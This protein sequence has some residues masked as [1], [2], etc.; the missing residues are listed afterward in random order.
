[1]T[2]SIMDGAVLEK[3]RELCAALAAE[4]GIIAIRQRINAFIS[5]DR[6]RA[7]YE[8][9]M[10]AGQ[11]LQEKQERAQPLSM[12]EI[13]E[14]ERQRDA[15]FANPVARGFL[16]AQD[17]LHRLQDSIHQH[18]TKTLE[19]GRVPEAE[20]FEESCGPGCGCGH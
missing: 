10:L 15:F 3:T 4:P 19:L 9:L 6:A 7:Q 18:I 2:T 1:M 12:E 17:E 20:D 8:Q 5:D 16:E 14:F 11:R 13:Q